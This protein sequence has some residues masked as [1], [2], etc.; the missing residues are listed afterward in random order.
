MKR[1]CAWPQVVAKRGA[2]EK[3]PSEAIVTESGWQVHR[4]AE[5][6]L[7]KLATRRNLPRAFAARMHLR[8]L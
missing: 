2:H 8:S 4:L 3:I 1:G 7:R 5:A 6:G